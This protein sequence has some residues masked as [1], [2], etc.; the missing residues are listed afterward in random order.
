MKTYEFGHF[1]SGG[2]AMKTYLFSYEFENAKW[3]F[4]IKAKT[5]SEARERL[6]ALAWAKLDGELVATIP[7]PGW[8]ARL[9]GMR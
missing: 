4:E 7:C 3:A 8:L 2:W 9:L 6:R 5:E 1:P